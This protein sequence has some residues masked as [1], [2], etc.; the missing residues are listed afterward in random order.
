MKR[1]VLA[2][3]GSRA[4]YGA[5]RPVFRAIAESAALELRLLVTGMHLAPRFRRS[6]EEIEA[7]DFG[8]RHVVPV[9]PE[10]GSGTAMS[11][12]LGRSLIA[13]TE[14]IARVRPEVVLLQGDRGE[15][16]AAAAAAAHLNLPVV[17]MSGGDR[18]GTIDDAI[19]NAIT[20][21]AHVHLT[22]CDESSARL[23]AMGEPRSRIFQVGE[24]ALDVILNL[25]PL[26]RPVL[27]AELALDAEEPIVLATQ[28][29]VTDQAANAGGQVRE[30]LAALTELGMQT[31][32]THPN[33]DAGYE[34]IVDALES[35]QP[36]G[37]LHVVPHLGQRRYLSLM[38]EAALLV[39][40][41]SSGILEA[42]SFKLPV[43]NVGTRQHRRTRACNVIDAA[44]DRRE[45]GAAMHKALHDS[46]FRAGLAACRNPYGDGRCA[47]RTLDVLKRLRL[48]PALTAKWLD[49]GASVLSP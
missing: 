2:V 31:V 48:G 4:E 25:D 42:P 43:I 13:M 20:S 10:D 41:S 17:H 35:W 26:P 6:L 3:T 37:F 28:H 45:I 24:P 16:L 46:Q 7:D 34:A 15:M 39:G 36:R 8:V 18:T 30:T 9:F 23:R 44:C 1:V 33:T 38:R 27:C 22:T 5:M 21:F 47:E 19:R 40:N 14:V 11:T 32:F 49:D 29:S 12:A